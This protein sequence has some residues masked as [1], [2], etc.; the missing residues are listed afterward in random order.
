MSATEARDIY[1][2]IHDCLDMDE[3]RT[4]SC[5]YTASQKLP[6][7]IVH[8]FAK[9]SSN[10]FPILFFLCNTPWT[11]GNKVIIEHP[12]HLNCV[13]TLPREI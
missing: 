7:C 9:Y 10:K 13:A 11:I 2:P 12:P 5:L 3:S 8:I 1:G 4:R 6:I